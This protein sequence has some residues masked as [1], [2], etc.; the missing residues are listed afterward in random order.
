LGSGEIYCPVE[1]KIK[2]E[3]C[4]R[5]SSKEEGFSKSHE[6]R[7]YTVEFTYADGE[8]EVVK[9]VSH[10]PAEAYSYADTHRKRKTERPT[11]VVVKNRIGEILGKF[12]RGAGKVAGKV[13][14]VAVGAGKEALEAYREE[15]ERTKVR[16]EAYIE[17]LKE[18][19]RKGDI[20]ARRILRRK[21]I[22]W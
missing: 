11:Q 3:H 2:T 9:A 1:K 20:T 17:E 12:V 7:S 5:C 21:G 6:P 10:S 16:E 22:I 14:G 15:K 4:E 13:A 18:R 8:N 19:A